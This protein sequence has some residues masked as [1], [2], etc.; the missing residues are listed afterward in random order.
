MNHHR[1]TQ[2][3]KIKRNRTK[4]RKYNKTKKTK[5]GG[6]KKRST[7]PEYTTKGAILSAD[8][9]YRYSLKRIW[10][11]TKP[12]VLF[13]M[14]NPSTADADKDDR[15]IGRI[16][17]FAQSWGYGGA[18]V[19]NLYA[20]RS[21]DPKG[22]ET[23]AD[24]IG[25][26]NRQ[27]IQ[28]LIGSVDR[29]LYAWGNEKTEPQWLRELVKEPFCIALSKKGI[30]RHPLYLSGDSQPMLYLRDPCQEEEGGAGG[31]EGDE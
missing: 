1:S 11:E 28:S 2:K 14:L 20:F 9:V 12:K 27:H 13:I 19:A 5:Y 15:T 23:T 30:P 26:D 22:I 21:T 31:A 25:P 6:M 17:N 16:V 18:Y 10:D 3:I 29:V 7:K 4:R 24:P 8:G